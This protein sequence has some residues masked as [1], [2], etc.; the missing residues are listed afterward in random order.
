MGRINAK[1]TAM[2]KQVTPQFA[3]DGILK[4]PA[5]FSLGVILICSPLAAQNLQF[6]STYTVEQEGRIDMSTRILRDAFF[7]IDDDFVGL[8][9]HYRL[10]T[11]GFSMCFSKY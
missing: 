11:V 8:L 3:E 7:T 4:L 2:S 9:N 10:A 6:S 5:V 1:L